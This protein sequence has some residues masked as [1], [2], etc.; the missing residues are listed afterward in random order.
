MTAQLWQFNKNLKLNLT[1]NPPYTPHKNSMLIG[2]CFD[3]IHYGHLHFLKEAKKIA[4][5]L[6]IALEPDEKIIQAKKRSPVHTLA[7][8]AEIL[9][10]LRMVDEI[11]L[12][13]MM[14]DYESYLELVQYLQPTFIGATEGDKELKNKQ[15]QADTIG[16]TLKIVTENWEALSS[17]KILL[18]NDKILDVY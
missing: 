14:N 2:G 8:R 3:I 11:V 1:L 15:K 12:L 6:I 17:S 16:A 10:H 18:S 4:S 7:Q 13:P 9:S 5:Y